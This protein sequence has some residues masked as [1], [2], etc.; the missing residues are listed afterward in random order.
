M[1]HRR[2]LYA[3]LICLLP[4]LALAAQCTMKGA[5]YGP[6]KAGTETRYPF[7]PVTIA[8]EANPSKIIF[9]TVT[10]QAGELFVVGMPLDWN[11]AYRIT[12]HFPDRQRTYRRTAL[13]AEPHKGI[14]PIDIFVKDAPTNYYNLTLVDHGATD[15]RSKV[16][17][18]LVPDN[19]PLQER[20][21]VFYLTDGG[22]QRVVTLANGLIPERVSDRDMGRLLRLISH[23]TGLLKT[24]AFARYPSPIC[25]LGGVLSI[26]VTA[27]SL[28]TIT[29]T[30]GSLP[31]IK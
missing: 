27:S 15:Q 30:T 4:G 24:V 17:R 7:L 3:L 8:E 12:L 25:G 23:R 6:A 13:T 21:L 20:N 26:E 31:E 28:P 1:R 16:I 14:I 11:K 9:T 2:Y 5:I 22:R 10:N 29:K 19:L 18:N